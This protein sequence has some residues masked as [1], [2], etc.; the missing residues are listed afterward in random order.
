[1]KAGKNANHPSP[2]PLH[3]WRKRVAV[4]GAGPGG[5]AVADQLARLG[6]PVT[7]YEKLPV[8]GG[9]MAVGIPEYRLPRD[10]IA[11]EYQR[12][13][14][15]G[16]E[17]KLNT[18]IGTNGDHTLDD[19]FEIGY[20][21]ICL[22]IGAHKSQSL[23]IPGEE[24]IGVVHG[25]DVLQT[26][27]LSQQLDDRKYLDD[28][29]RTLHRGENTRVAVLGGG[30]TAMDASRSL[31][32]LGIKDVT[33]LYRR[34]RAEM[35][36]IPE[37]VEDAE[38]EGV[39]LEFL[40][41][42]VRVL[43]NQKGQVVGLECIRMKLGAPDSS[44]RRRPVPI[45][46]SEFV[47][48]LDLVVLAI[49]QSP[50]LD[51]MGADHEIAVTRNNRINVMDINF[52]TNRPG[53]FAVGDAITRNN[54]VVIEAIG[55]G[56]KAAAAIDIFLQGHPPAEI[57][58][59]AQDVP[60]ANRE[61]TKAELAP[62][63]RIPI[64]T[65]PTE[66]RVS[67]FAEVE[68]G[69]TAEQAIQE[70]QRCLACGP[71]SECQACVQVC[72]PQAINHDQQE[73]FAELEIGAIIF[74]GSSSGHKPHIQMS[75]SQGIYQIDADDALLGSAIAAQCFTALT[76]INT[77]STAL[78]LKHRTPLS[79]RFQTLEHRS[80]KIPCRCSQSEWRLHLR[81]R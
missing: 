31:M 61:M 47:F 67:S 15:L 19:L 28:F 13:Q 71:C 66:Q 59:D 16:V 53:V 24:L 41:S 73:T 37:E 8:I 27:N 49:G 60:I 9:M 65:I 32:R 74:A 6:Y 21:A 72:K 30:N 4:V 38:K 55:M 54:M 70:A 51:F 48:D 12:I 2:F 42:P 36:A 5:M 29:E 50:D 18:T 52:M 44:G 1:M 80:P 62:K 17:I 75:P 25:I 7:V 39:Q 46:D 23:Q 14:D 40:V 35:P 11:R 57:R 45:A 79:N 64:P 20:D 58:V 43:G 76:K 81:V 10:V 3:P 63:P 77:P 22:A 69:Y 56:K 34:T 68:L 26:I 78:N 33:I